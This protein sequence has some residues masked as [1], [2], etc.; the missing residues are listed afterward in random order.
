[1]YGSLPIHFIIHH[2]VLE[3]EANVEVTQDVATTLV[4]KYPG[5]IAFLS[6]DKGFYSK[7]NK[8]FK[9]FLYGQISNY[10]RSPIAQED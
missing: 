4:E 3:N 9:G 7:E 1:M 10:I 2:Q 6:F 5:L 8:T